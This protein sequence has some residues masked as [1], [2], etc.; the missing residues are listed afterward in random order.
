MSRE[1][2]H[3][4]VARALRVMIDHVDEIVS[5]VNVEQEFYF[6]FRSGFFSVSCWPRYGARLAFGFN[7]YPN[8]K[9]T[10]DELAEVYRTDEFLDP[11]EERKY[12]VVSYTTEDY[13]S[14]PISEL[15][16]ALKS[17]NDR[18]D[19]ILDDILRSA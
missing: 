14:L 8:F 19:D 3:D 16:D 15:F 10:V 1:L 13:P 2:Q 9:G 17:R 12:R 11:A 18:I 7:V 6:A 4:K 5:V